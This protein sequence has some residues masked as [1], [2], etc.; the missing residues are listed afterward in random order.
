M[1][2]S[3]LGFFFQEHRDL[4]ARIAQIIKNTEEVKV[5]VVTKPKRKDKYAFQTRPYD[6]TEESVIDDDELHSLLGV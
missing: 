4:E 1:N 3:N 5:A 2:N 6:E